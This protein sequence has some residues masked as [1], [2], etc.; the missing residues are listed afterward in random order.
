LEAEKGMSG[1][2]ALSQVLS[3]VWFILPAYLA[4]GGALVLGGGVPLDLGGKMGDGRRI[5]GDGVTIR[6]TLGGIGVGLIVGL[7]Q[8]LGT[9]PYLGAVLG[10]AMGAGSMFGDALGS[11]GKRRLGISRGKSAPVLDQMGFLLF[12][13]AFA[14]LITRVSFTTIIILLILTPTLHLVTNAIAY[15]LGMKKVWY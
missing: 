14:A 3:A 13:L 2:S 5:L 11:F 15:Q 1:E 9:D 10:F 7:L 4:N 8:G 12:A 6:G